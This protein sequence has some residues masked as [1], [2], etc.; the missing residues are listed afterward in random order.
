ML[1]LIL[2]LDLA[3]GQLVVDSLIEQ[4]VE[5]TRKLVLGAMGWTLMVVESVSP[6]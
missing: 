6:T 2:G 5:V 4:E 3:S 1:E